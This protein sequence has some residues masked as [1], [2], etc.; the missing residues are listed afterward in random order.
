MQDRTP[1][2]C[3]RCRESGLAGLGAFSA[4]KPLLDFAPV[5]RRARHDGWTP[6]RQRAFI[7][8]LAET[9]AVSLAAKAVNMSPEGAYYLRRQPGAE[10]FRAAW[11]AALDLGAEIVDGAALERSIHGV[12][13]PVFHKGEQVG[14]RRVFNE[15]LTMFMLAHRKPDKYGHGLKGGTKHPDTIAREAE[16]ADTAERE[17]KLIA[18]LQKMGTQYMRVARAERAARRDGAL[19]SA[20]FYARQMTYIELCLICG[21]EAMILVRRAWSRRLR[22]QC[23]PLPP[24]P[25]PGDFMARWVEDMRTEVWAHPESWKRVY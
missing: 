9:G 3:D 14:E 23:F 4:M 19:D 25:D 2:L 15:R 24:L 8:A 18:G 7:A 1:V 20:E 21:P 5:P 22:E 10:E 6:D 13:V 12:A 16:E 11:D 17:A